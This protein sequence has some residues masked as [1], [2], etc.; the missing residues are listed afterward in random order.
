MTPAA[1]LFEAAERL[2][3]AKRKE[4]QRAVERASIGYKLYRAAKLR[5]AA[6]AALRAGVTR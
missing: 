4:A 1:Q 6:H 5:D 3:E 2:A